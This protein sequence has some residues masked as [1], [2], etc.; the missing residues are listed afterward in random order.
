MSSRKVQQYT[1]L[2][3]MFESRSPPKAWWL[4]QDAF[5]RTWSGYAHSAD[6]PSQISDFQRAQ[7]MTCGPLLLMPGPVTASQAPLLLQATCQWP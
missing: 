2:A 4:L 7:S 3:C 5:V 6:A 1:A